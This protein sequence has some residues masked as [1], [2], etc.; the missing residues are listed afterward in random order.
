MK[1]TMDYSSRKQR[2]D[3][4]DATACNLANFESLIISTPKKLK[5]V[6]ANPPVD[7]PRQKSVKLSLDWGADERTVEVLKTLKD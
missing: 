7:L 6:D 4:I 3:I 5:A 1:C 2:E